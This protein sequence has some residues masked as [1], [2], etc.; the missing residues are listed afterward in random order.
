MKQCNK[1]LSLLFITLFVHFSALSQTTMNEQACAKGSPDACF[2]T[3]LDYYD[4]AGVPKDI[5]SGFIF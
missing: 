2:N 1:M 5:K 3:A 4:G